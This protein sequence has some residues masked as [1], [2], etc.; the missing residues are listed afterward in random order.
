MYNTIQDGHAFKLEG[1][2]THCR[3]A[4]VA[5]GTYYF[6]QKRL[7]LQQLPGSGLGA[8][9]ARVSMLAGAI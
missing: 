8:D 1:H 7:A 5:Q 9:P 3:V 4:P 2:L 6:R